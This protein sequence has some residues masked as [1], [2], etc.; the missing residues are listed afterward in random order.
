MWWLF[1]LV[2]Y[3]AFQIVYCLAAITGVTNDVEAF[4]LLPN[5]L[6]D[7]TYMNWAGCIITS[8]VL[9]IL[10]PLPWLGRLIYTLFHI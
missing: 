9:F 1:V 10:L 6:H 4:E 2:G 7:N 3:C 5:D 8:I